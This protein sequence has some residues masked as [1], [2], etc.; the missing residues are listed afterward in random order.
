MKYLVKALETNETFRNETTRVYKL[1]NVSKRNHGIEFVSDTADESLHGQ[2]LV[3]PYVGV[4]KGSKAHDAGM[5]EGQ[6]LV[7]INDYLVTDQCENIQDVNTLFEEAIAERE[8]VKL[9]V[10]DREKWDEFMEDPSQVIE[11]ANY[12]QVLPTA[13]QLKTPSESSTSIKNQA[14][15][16]IDSSNEE[17]AEKPEENLDLFKEPSFVRENT[18]QVKKNPKEKSRVC[19]IL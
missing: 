6:R 9:T 13:A 3:F 5:I 18:P 10:L 7:A 16:V 2:Y 19:M 12:S 11:H 17:A 8:R 14:D 1:R 4:S 15:Q